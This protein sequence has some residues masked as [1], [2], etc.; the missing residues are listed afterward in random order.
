[1]N[2]LPEYRYGAVRTMVDLHGKYLQEFLDV[3]KQAKIVDIS[4]PENRI[5]DGRDMLSAINDKTNT[6]L[7]ERLF[8]DGNDNAWAV[9]EG[10]WK[11]LYSRRGQQL[12]LY[13]LEE[14]PVE[15]FNLVKEY[16]E[17]A[18]DLNA[19]YTNWRNEMGT[20]MGKK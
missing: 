12:E 19:K 20:P 8:F 1:M 4:L 7:H 16:P 2:T 6:P 15:E 3:W 5:Y 11:L 9:R 18:S 10:K 14:D 13:N 17:I